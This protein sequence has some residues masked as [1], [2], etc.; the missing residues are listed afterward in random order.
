MIKLKHP[1]VYVHR[2]LGWT[3]SVSTVLV[4]YLWLNGTRGLQ[5]VLTTNVVL[6]K[7][8]GNG[9]C[10]ILHW[11]VVISSWLCGIWNQKIQP[12]TIIDFSSA[13]LQIQLSCKSRQASEAKRSNVKLYERLVL[14]WTRGH[15]WRVNKH[16]WQHRYEC[17]TCFVVSHR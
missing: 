1:I 14:G 2:N 6:D 4:F 3:L 5:R 10:Q 16:C 15:K 12:K 17:N 7:Q 11:C 9:F 8:S 13:V